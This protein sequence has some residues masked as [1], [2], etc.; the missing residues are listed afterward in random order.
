MPPHADSPALELILEEVE[1]GLL[2]HVGD[3]VALEAGTDQH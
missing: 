1:D 3:L 2:H